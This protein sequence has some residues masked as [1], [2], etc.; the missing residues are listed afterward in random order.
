[1]LTFDPRASDPARA[2]QEHSVA[3]RLCIPGLWCP[4][5]QLPST[6]RTH[7]SPTEHPSWPASWAQDKLRK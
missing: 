6:P 2:S 4:C 1:M 7:M 5:P 3:Q